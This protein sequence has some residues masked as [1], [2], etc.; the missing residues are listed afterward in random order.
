ME[1]FIGT[2]YC[3]KENRINTKVIFIKIKASMPVA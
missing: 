2:E 3:T 1:G